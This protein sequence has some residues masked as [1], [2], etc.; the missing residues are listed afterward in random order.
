[1]QLSSVLKAAGHQ[2]Q[3]A[4]CALEDPVRV[5][6]EFQP[7]ILA[8]SVITGSQRY[9]LEL[10]RRLRAKVNAFSAFGGPHPTFFPEMIQEEGVDGVCVGEGEGPLLDLAQALQPD[11]TLADTHLPNWHLKVG[12]EVIRNE[13]RPYVDLDSLP[14]PD[15]ALVYDKDP[16]TRRS[17]IKHFMGLDG[18]GLFFLVEGN[19]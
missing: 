2:V 17:K 18:L 9:Y 15:Y 1:M 19:G 16:V 14:P 11:G 8:Y 12:G 13:V 3:L 5:A 10:N 4:I 6:L 7:H